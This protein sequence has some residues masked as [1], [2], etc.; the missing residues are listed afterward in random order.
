MDRNPLDLVRSQVGYLEPDGEHWRLAMVPMNF[1]V[2]ACIPWA[3]AP[4]QYVIT[5]PQPT[6]GDYTAQGMSEAT[7]CRLWGA[8]WRIFKREPDE[9]V[10]SGYPIWYLERSN[11]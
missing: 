4:P 11:A 6:L 10:I 8:G 7:A 2:L 3:G 5:H 9:F 1:E